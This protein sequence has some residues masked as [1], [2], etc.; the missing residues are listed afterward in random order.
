MPAK[1]TV[2]ILLYKR[3]LTIKKLAEK[4]TEATGHKY[5]RTSLSNKIS[6]SSLRFDEMEAIAKILEYKIVFEDLY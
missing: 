6:R 3:G 5:T 2:K 4:L 1:D